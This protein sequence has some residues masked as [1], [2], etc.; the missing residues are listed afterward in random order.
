MGLLPSFF[1]VFPT[2]CKVLQ[3][4]GVLP[5]V[6]IVVVLELI[7]FFQFFFTGGLSIV[8][9][10][11]GLPFCRVFVTV[12]NQAAVVPLL[13]HVLHAVKE[14][15]CR[16]TVLLIFQ[17]QLRLSKFFYSSTIWKIYNPPCRQIY[18]LILSN[19]RKDRCKGIM[20][21]R[22]FTSD[23]YKFCHFIQT[24]DLH[25]WQKALSLLIQHLN[26]PPFSLQFVAKSCFLR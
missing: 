13:V 26:S 15:I 3:N 8:M 14:L 21:S 25:S 17:L 7:N 1:H 5:I 6:E 19:V 23:A 22:T 18:C 20:Y 2:L 4:L 12:R 10:L 24:R 16:F 9:H 11:I